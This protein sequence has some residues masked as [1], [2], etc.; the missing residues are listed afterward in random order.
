MQLRTGEC[1][2]AVNRARKEI[3]GFTGY[4]PGIDFL[5]DYFTMRKEKYEVLN[6][7]G[8]TKNTMILE[9]YLPEREV[10]RLVNEL[11]QRFRVAITISEPEEDEDVPVLLENNWVLLT[12]GADHRDVCPAGEEGYRPHAGHGGVL[13]FV[14]WPDALRRRLWLPDGACISPRAE[15]V[16]AGRQHAQNDEDVSLFRRVHHLLGRAVRHLVRRYCAGYLQKLCHRPPP[17]MAIWFDPVSDPMK[18]LLFSLG[19]G[20]LHLFLGLG[21]HFY[22]SGRLASAGTPSATQ[23]RFIFWCWGRRR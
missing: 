8:M 12:D 16:P 23:R 11:E 1:E 19:L 15:K 3:A 21:V 2:E 22:Q 20:I 5:I 9:G 13:L 4:E 17:R 10:T 18:L 14:F 6:R 7:L